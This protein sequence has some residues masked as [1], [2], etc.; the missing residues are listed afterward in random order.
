MQKKSFKSVIVI[1]VGWLLFWLLQSVLMS[2]GSDMEFYLFKNIVIVGL[3]LL[4][5]IVNLKVLIPFLLKK[6]HLLLYTLC[7]IGII[8]LAFT[9]TF[10]LVNLFLSFIY[11][12]TASLGK[13]NIVTDYWRILSGSSF[14]SLALVISTIYYFYSRQPRSHV[15]QEEPSAVPPPVI[16]TDVLEIKEGNKVHYIHK[17]DVLYIKGLREYVMWITDKEKIV[18]LDSLKSIESKYDNLGFKRVHKSYIVNTAHIAARSTNHLT[19]HGEEI[20]IGRTYK[21]KLDLHT[22][23]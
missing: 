17:Q 7:S 21:A 9:F 4:V 13:I 18:S 20:P 11:S 12:S 19:I 23:N 5:V 22:L 6:K 16:T 2:S 3:Q 8:Y 10:P 1:G 15:Q 14:Y